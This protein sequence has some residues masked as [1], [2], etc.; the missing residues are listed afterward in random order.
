MKEI[1]FGNVKEEKTPGEHRKTK[2][3]KEIAYGNVNEGKPSGEHNK[4]KSEG[5]NSVIN[6]MKSRKLH[7]ASNMKTGETFSHYRGCK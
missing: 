3:M 4:T 6:M 1:S 5:N 7:N 2:T